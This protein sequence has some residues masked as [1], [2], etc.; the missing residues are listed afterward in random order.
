MDLIR[1][2]LERAASAAEA[3]HIITRLLERHGQGGN[4]G[5]LVQSFYHN[6]F[7]IADA[8]EAFVLETVNRDWVVERVRAPRS[9][10]NIYSIGRH[11]DAASDG[12][13]GF[14]RAAGWSSDPSP[15]YARAIANPARE[16]IGNAG[17]RHASTTASMTQR[18]GQITPLDVMRALRDH[19]DAESS[20]LSWRADCTTRR[21][22][23]MHAGAM[24]K[25]GHTV[26]SLISHLTEDASVHW[27]TGTSTPCLSI[28]KPVCLDAPLPSQGP[29]PT[30]QFD[31]RALWWRGEVLNRRALMLGMGEVLEELQPERDALEQRFLERMSSVTSTT[32]RHARGQIVQECWREASELL[33]LWIARLR[34]RPLPATANDSVAEAWR[35]MNALA[36]FEL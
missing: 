25:P 5:H 15:D 8:R 14:V 11:P 3:L 34:S 13:L 22:V 1:L 35:H 4:G 10:S 18:V 20:Q 17:A 32:D 7:I 28:F 33:D 26:G 16:H 36:R 29:L 24:E 21:S 31:P 12:L 19:G 27:V 6:G 30:D 2:A 9:I 23:C